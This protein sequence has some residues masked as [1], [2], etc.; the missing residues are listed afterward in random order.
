MPPKKKKMEKKFEKW[1]VVS[2]LRNS[3]QDELLYVFATSSRDHDGA[4]KKTVSSLGR[5]PFWQ[6]LPA[7][8]VLSLSYSKYLI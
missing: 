1:V 7:N 3:K 8:G 4:K 2:V 6:T 5:E